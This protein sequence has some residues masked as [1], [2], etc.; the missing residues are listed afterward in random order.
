MVRAAGCALGG[1][2]SATSIAWTLAILCGGLLAVCVDLFLSLQWHEE[3]VQELEAQLAAKDDDDADMLLDDD[4]DDDDPDG[5]SCVLQG[6][7]E[8]YAQLGEPLKD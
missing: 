7:V 1:I 6:L 5:D 8:Y 3:R 2:V 4:D